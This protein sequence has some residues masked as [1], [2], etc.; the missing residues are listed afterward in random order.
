MDTK[1]D[2]KVLNADH[3]PLGNDPAN[4][5]VH[6]N[7]IAAANAQIEI[8][9]DKLDHMRRDVHRGNLKVIKRLIKG[10]SIKV[11]KRK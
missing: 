5:P 4:T 6:P 10:T 9:R 7:D 3:K 11:E 8:L 2:M 1:K